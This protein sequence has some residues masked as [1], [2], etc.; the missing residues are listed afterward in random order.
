M[1]LFLP[2]QR[3]SFPLRVGDVIL[4]VQGSPTPNMRGWL[5]R[6]EDWPATGDPPR[7]AGEPVTVRYLRNGATEEASFPLALNRNPIHLVRS[8]SGRATGFSKAVA[9]QFHQS[10]PEYCGSPVIDPTGRVVGI[11]IAKLETIEVLVLPVDE[12]TQ[13]LRSLEAA[14]GTK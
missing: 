9:A 12:V 1:E 8:S 7:I 14:G 10:R 2:G 11:L 13:A 4:D 3:S 5:R 6:F